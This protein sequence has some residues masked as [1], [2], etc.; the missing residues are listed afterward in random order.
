MKASNSVM[1]TKALKTSIKELRTIMGEHNV[2]SF[3]FSI[4]ATGRSLEG[5]INLKF[6][7]QSYQTGDYV[8]VHGNDLFAITEEFGRRLGWDRRHKPL[9][10]SYNEDRE[11]IPF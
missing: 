9:E 11:E 3:D 7:L 4:T 8:T 5:E 6:T 1:L 10:L 2:N